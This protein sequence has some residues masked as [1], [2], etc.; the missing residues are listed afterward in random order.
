MGKTYG[1]ICNEQMTEV[2]LKLL[3][4]TTKISDIKLTY[5]GTR[6]LIIPALAKLN[7]LFEFLNKIVV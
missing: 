4:T 2:L 7:Y 6:F 1:G 3:A 5:I